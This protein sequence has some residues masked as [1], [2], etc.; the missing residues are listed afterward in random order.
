MYQASPRHA[1]G[2]TSWSASNAWSSVTTSTGRIQTL[3]CAA[4]L[5]QDDIDGLEMMDS[6]IIVSRF[7]FYGITM[8]F[9]KMVGKTLESHHVW[10]ENYGK[11]TEVS[12]DLLWFLIWIL[13]GMI[14]GWYWDID[15][16][17]PSGKR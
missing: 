8:F 12:M 5:T 7:L 3:R 2:F 1:V 16:E 17:L 13:F 14:M 10:W 6:T 15:G 4:G 11:L 9:L